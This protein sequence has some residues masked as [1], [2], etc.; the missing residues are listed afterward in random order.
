MVPGGWATSWGGGRGGSRPPGRQ[1]VRSDLLV[2]EEAPG[3]SRRR[4][5][6]STAPVL[7]L[8][9]QKPISVE[10]CEMNCTRPLE[11]TQQASS[12]ACDSK[13][14]SHRM[15][16]LFAGS[17]ALPS[18]HQERSEWPPER[19]GSQYCGILLSPEKGDSDTCYLMGEPRVS[20]KIPTCA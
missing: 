18:A 17:Q 6:C 16:C 20:H 13:G 19:V 14:T 5:C 7:S 8:V 12:L 10:I 2:P 3:R 11:S 15:F 9:K 1:P 4:V